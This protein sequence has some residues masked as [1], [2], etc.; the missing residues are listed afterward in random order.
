MGVQNT[1]Q[2]VE[3]VKKF[4]KMPD[5]RLIS[6]LLYVNVVNHNNND[7]KDDFIQQ[8]HDAET[9]SAGSVSNAIKYSNSFAQSGT[10]PFSD[11]FKGFQNRGRDLMKHSFAE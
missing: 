9:A 10:S 7:S 3:Q 1:N 2:R 11:A 6:G 4:I 5:R 8:L